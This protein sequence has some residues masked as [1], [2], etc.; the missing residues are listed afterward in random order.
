MNC[1]LLRYAMPDDDQ[2]DDPAQDSVRWRRVLDAFGLTNMYRVGEYGSIRRESAVD[3]IIAD[4][5]MPRSMLFCLVR[6]Q[7]LLADLPNNTKHWKNVLS[8]CAV[9]AGCAADKAISPLS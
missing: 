1:R 9:R 2:D 8:P 6:L 3:F 7:T 5:A 4:T